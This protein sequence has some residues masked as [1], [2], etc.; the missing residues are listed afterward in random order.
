MKLDL[1][2]RT[3]NYAVVNKPSGMVCDASHTNNIITALTNEFTKI[4]PSVNSSQFRLVQRLDRF[5][6]GGLV[7]ARNKKW[8][9]KV[10][11]SFFQEGTLRLTRRYVGLIALDQIPESTQGTI[12]FPIQALEK[13]YRGKNKSRELFTYSA[14]THYKLIPSA[15][16]IIKGVFPVFQQGPILPIILELETGRKNQIRDHIIQKFGVPLLNDDNF[17]DFK[18]NSEIPKDVNSKLYKSNQIALHSGLVIMENN[19]TS[20][21]FLFPVNNVYDRELWGSFVNEKGEFIDEIR[22]GLINFKIQGT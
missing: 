16:R 13:D 4:L 15:R 2:K 3:F 11:K 1:V 5:V 7:V 8:A 9:D 21:Q 6:T 12:D 19:G 18:L 17:S 22:N 20:Q 10:R 14:V